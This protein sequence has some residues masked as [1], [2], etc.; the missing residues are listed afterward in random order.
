MQ[1]GFLHTCALSV[2][3]AIYCWGMNDHSQ[4]GDG[5]DID[6]AR[7]VKVRGGDLRFTAMTVGSS[8]TCAISEEKAF[9]CWGKNDQGQL[10]NGELIGFPYPIKFSPPPPY[11]PFVQISAGSAHTLRRHR[12]TGELY[13]WG[14]NRYGQEPATTTTNRLTRSQ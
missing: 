2:T 9:F 11:P 4:L 6:R 7:P 5:T 3:K 12:N 1:S 8:H 10:G 14:D 13:C